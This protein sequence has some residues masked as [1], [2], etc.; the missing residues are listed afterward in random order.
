MAHYKRAG[1]R[2]RN[3]QNTMDNGS[4]RVVGNSQGKW[5]FSWRPKYS[6]KSAVQRNQIGKEEL[7]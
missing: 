6:H 4:A 7:E 2:G 3:K 1:H 5:G